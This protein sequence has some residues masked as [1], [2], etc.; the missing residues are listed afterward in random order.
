MY[1]TRPQGFGL[2]EGVFKQKVSKG[3]FI[4]I[5]ILPYETDCNTLASS[6]IFQKLYLL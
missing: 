3:E 5:E 4:D 6:F 2:G 1:R